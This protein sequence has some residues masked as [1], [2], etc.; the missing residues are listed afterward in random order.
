VQELL[1]TKIDPALQ[2]EV[3]T[4]L[5]GNIQRS[6]SVLWLSRVL[7]VLAIGGVL[8]LSFL[9]V[10][11]L[12]KQQSLIMLLQLANANEASARRKVEKISAEI[13][14]LYNHA[15]C[16]YHSLDKNGVFSAINQTELNWLG[17]K[18]EE[19][20]GKLHIT[21]VVDERSRELF[22]ENF[23][24]FKE[25]GSLMDLRFVMVSKSGRSFP[26][27]VNATAIYDI[28]GN[29]LSSRS[30]VFD[31]TSQV[32]FEAELKEAKKIAD[33][34][35]QVKEQFLAN[36]SHEIRTPV[37]SM[38][39]FTNLLQKTKLN[40][41][42]QQ[43]VALIQS[44]SENLLAIINEILD[45]SKIEAGMLRIENQPFSLRGLCNSIETMFHHR[46]HEKNL[47]FAVQVQEDIPDTLNGDPIRLTQI[48]VNLITNAIKF[49][50][51]GSIKVQIT[52][53]VQT[54]ES[55]RLIFS[56]TDTG[57]GMAQDMLERIFERFEQGDT[58]TTRKYGGTGLGLAIVKKLVEIQDGEIRVISEP[59]KGTEFQLEMEYGLTTNGNQ[60][61]ITYDRDTESPD[62]LFLKGIR[63]LIVEDNEMNQ[64]LMKHT[65]QSWQMEFEI[66]AHGKQAIDWLEKEKFDL[67]LLDIQ[68]PV[69]DG[70][71]AA[72]AIRKEL[73][74]HIP[75]I[76]M[77]AHAM[78]GER[79]KC[80]SHGMNDYIPKPL[81]ER[82]LQQLLKKYLQKKGESVELL[83]AELKYIDMVFLWDLVME[84]KEF[85]QNV[86]RQFMKQFPGEM[87]SLKEAV[88]LADN[89]R[90]AALAH[91]I[92]STVSVLGKKTPYFAQLENLEKT[93][94]SRGSAR[95]LTTAFNSLNE[96][97]QLLL[98]DIDRLMKA[99]LE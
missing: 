57:I 39:G 29:Y 47:S 59:G 91:H 4:N 72:Q 46:A 10:R 76:A 36:M 16:G 48:L 38:I 73:K 90:V 80:L 58:D 21:D 86:L 40:E 41:D 96:H 32:Y 84:N 7:T 99:E 8:T 35:A 1:V 65:F 71:A 23:Q 60:T 70:Y 83:K 33:L 85:M 55:I 24:L 28:K 77:T 97:K 61:H 43:Y 50:S 74:S 53:P 20:I 68:M 89:K 6:E 94:L 67:V 11:R 44:A 45:L 75:I 82:E 15:P 31:I 27:T 5:N 66:A 26:V 19:V 88:A 17:Y 98:R 3:S 51:E 18:R 95:Q 34:S 64:L 30:T 49:T 54:A 42:Q 56:I 92:Q 14:D 2:Q 78:P 87:E 13:E 37:N 81:H 22:K 62:P 12:R 63:I 9:V 25:R 52:M 93:A 79:E 69:M